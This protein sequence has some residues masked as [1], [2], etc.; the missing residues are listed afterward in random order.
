M[1]KIILSIFSILIFSCATK[2]SQDQIESDLMNY[3]NFVQ[4]GNYDEAVNYM[5]TKFWEFYDKE[6]YLK[7]LN[8]LSKKTGNLLFENMAITKISDRKKIDDNY[9]KIIDY[10]TNI[11]FDSSQISENVI[12]K[13]KS[14]FG[15]KNVEIDTINKKLKI[16]NES[17]II[18]V[19]DKNVDQWRFLEQT[20]N[21][22][23]KLYGLN[24]WLEL[25]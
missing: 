2:I 20:Q 5:P 9:F 23:V 7:R 3:L 22:I 21:G 6:N 25:H 19:Y 13:Y 11:L 18:A 24:T 4:K 1:R 16:L 17:S 14:N 15:E 8:Q 12:E 10:K